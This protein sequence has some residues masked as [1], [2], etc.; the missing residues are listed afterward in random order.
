MASQE[1]MTHATSASGVTTEQDSGDLGSSLESCKSDAEVLYNNHNRMKQILSAREKLE[2]A[3]HYVRQKYGEATASIVHM[4]PR[5]QI[6]RIIYEE[7]MAIIYLK[8]ISGWKQRKNSI[9]SIL[10]RLLTNEI[11]WWDAKNQLSRYDR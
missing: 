7:D 5:C 6:D 1:P 11:M 3:E 8:Q 9:Q 2:I 4:A 10:D